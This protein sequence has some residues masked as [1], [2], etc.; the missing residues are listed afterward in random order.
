MPATL[1]AMAPCLGRNLRLG[2]SALIVT[3]LTVCACATG[4]SAL[5]FK[6]PGQVRGGL[7][8]VPHWRAVPPPG[9]TL[10]SASIYDSNR[11]G[12]G[13]VAPH[14]DSVE[15]LGSAVPV[16]A[17]IVVSFSEPMAQASVQRAF[18]IRP[19]LE[20]VLRWVDDFTLRFQPY[21]L[22]HGVTYEVQVGGRSV[23]GMP[24]TGQLRWS[25]T[26]VAGPP[27][28]LAPGPSTIRVPILMYHYIRVNSD[29]RDWLGFA[30]SVTPSDFAAQMDWLARNGYHPITA[31]D[32]YA[33]LSGARGLPSRPVILSFDDGYADFYTAALPILRSHDFKAV[34]YVVSGFIGQPNYMT[35]AQIV[36]ADRSGIEIGSHTI[37]H[38]DLAKTSAGGVR[39]QVTASKQALEQLLGHPVVSFCYPSGRFNSSVV[40]AVAA[41]GY[42][43]ATTTGSGST[44][45]LPDRYVWGRV[46]I[47]GSMSLEQFAFALNS[48][49]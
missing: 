32:L 42:H 10:V 26:T 40:S 38:A 11:E 35:A 22:A 7:N 15:P 28:V 33:Y 1:A 19:Q 13:R 47:S 29:R 18:A 48:G 20:G 27:L 5:T 6:E 37:N 31:E 9:P 41:A 8:V 49:A 3:L 45:A 2:A 4:V 44:H 24:A 39:V 16:N 46:R 25:F 17:A 34:S 36:E 14:L 12:V 43:D 23:R 30:L 21:G